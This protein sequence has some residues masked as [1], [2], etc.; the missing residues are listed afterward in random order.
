MARLMNANMRGASGDVA[1]IHHNMDEIVSST[2]T[3]NQRVDNVRD[4]LR[5]IA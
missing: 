3:A 1:L 5:K 2:R 4:E